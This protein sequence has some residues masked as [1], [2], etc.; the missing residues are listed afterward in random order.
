MSVKG[1]C[2]WCGGV[3][4]P[5]TIEQIVAGSHACHECKAINVPTRDAAGV[6]LELSQQLQEAQAAILALSRLALAT[7]N[8][9]MQTRERQRMAQ[10]R[11][12]VQSRADMVSVSSAGH[13]FHPG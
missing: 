10:L 5:S 11:Q 12:M 6:I 4:H 7:D 2:H 8:G 13:S 9:V 3:L 1:I